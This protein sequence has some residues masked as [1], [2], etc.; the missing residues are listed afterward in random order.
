MNGIDIV[1]LPQVGFKNKNAEDRKWYTAEELNA[2]ALRTVEQGSSDH[3]YEKLGWDL[4]SKSAGIQSRQGQTLTSCRCRFFNVSEPRDIP[5]AVCFRGESL[6]VT[7]KKTK[8][9]ARYQ[10]LTRRRFFSERTLRCPRLEPLG[11]F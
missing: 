1:Y 2:D 7:Q 8:R 4:R 3:G 9:H 6:D 10:R 11:L 5:W